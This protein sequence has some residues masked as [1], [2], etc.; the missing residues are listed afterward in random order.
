VVR[1]LRKKRPKNWTR[2]SLARLDDEALIELWSTVFQDRSVLK[3]GEFV[4]EKEPKKGAP[5]EAIEL[6]LKEA[7][8]RQIPLETLTNRI[9][10]DT[11]SGRSSLSDVLA[12]TA[13]K[14]YEIQ[15]AQAML[16]V[17][18]DVID[19]YT[20]DAVVTGEIT[21]QPRQVDLLL[22][23]K[24]GTVACEFK[25][26]PDRL[27]PIEKLEAFAA[28]MKDVGAARG[29][30]ITPCGYHK[31]AIATAAHHGIVLYRL[32]PASTD[33]VHRRFADRTAD[34]R[35]GGRYWFLQNS[36]GESWLFEADPTFKPRTAAP[37]ASSAAD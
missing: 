28:K 26:Y 27:V 22:A 10:T 2:E 34:I 3:L 8:R 35:D 12:P 14:H 7:E 9:V 23:T 15:A 6:V 37:E 16:A 19:S 20:F 32:R 31:G 30:F 1:R 36:D 13:W 33:E 21:G 29:V 17:A 18:K 24:R 5:P 11:L 4:I 25:Q